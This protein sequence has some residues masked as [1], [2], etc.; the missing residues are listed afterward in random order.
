[1]R[2]AMAGSAAGE[3]LG[4][5]AQPDSASGVSS[6]LVENDVVRDLRHSVGNHFH[7]LYYWAERLGTDGAGADRA[8][9]VD[10]LNGAL[11]RFQ[12]F[13]ELGLRYFEPD[14]AAPMIMTGGDIAAASE[15]LLRTE[16][17]GCAVAVDVAEE[18]LDVAVRVD[19]QRFSYALRLVAEVLGGTAREAF[20]C[21]LTVSEDR[22]ECEFTIEATGGERPLE[23]PVMQWAIA[24]KAIA[25]QGG[26]LAPSSG[27][28]D[29][30]GGCTMRLP[31]G[32]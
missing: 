7:K 26:V 24:R 1:M 19:P 13:L 3:S 16:L 22:G 27:Q 23:A 2:G 4:G 15:S 5:V 10:E 20:G 21:A 8:E 17:P 30:V 18:A 29:A 31:L 25:M 6:L 9:L 14:A 11:H 12:E 32:K 28:E